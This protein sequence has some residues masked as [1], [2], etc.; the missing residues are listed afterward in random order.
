L[1][2]QGKVREG[3]AAYQ[4]M[5]DLRP[6][7]Q[8]YARAAHVRWLTGD[9]AGAIE[10]MR[11]ATAASSPN[12]PE[13]AA[14]AFTR[15]AL[16]QLQRGATKQAL[17]SCDTALS[18]QNDYAP[19]MLARGRTLLAMNRASEALV[20]LR[21][22]AKLNPLPDYQWALEDVINSPVVTRS[23][24]EDP[25]T[26]SLYLAT[27]NEDVEHAV[28]LAQQELTNRG[29]IFTHDALAWALAAAGRAAEAQQQMNQA[30]SEGTADARLYLH[31]GVIAALNNDSKQ[32]R[33]WL[34]EAAAIKQMLLPG[35]R[36][37]L[38]AWRQRIDPKN[39]RSKN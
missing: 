31:A 13:A 37:Q 21:R 1:I 38:D 9:L 23:N 20:E 29:D 12:D 3:A 22:A 34:E 18:L 8:S 33:R 10:L 7:L 24:T 2:D 39:L 26:L 32:A 4:K 27:R 19:A 36:V 15:L 25:R 30:L 6:D 14:W 17:E 11:L 16:Y 28:K 35:E 5:V